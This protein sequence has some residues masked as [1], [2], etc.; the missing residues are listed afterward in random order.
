MTLQGALLGPYWL[1]RSLGSGVAGLAMGPAHGPQTVPVAVEVLH[2]D[3]FTPMC[4]ALLDQVGVVA[5][6]HQHPII[7]VHTSGEHDGAVYVVL[8]Y[9]ADGSLAARTV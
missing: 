6:M 5:V 1:V 7:P 2:G 3:V 8:S 4:R 9:M